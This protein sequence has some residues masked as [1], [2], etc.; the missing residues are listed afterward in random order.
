MKRRPKRAEARLLTLLD[1]GW[2]IIGTRGRHGFATAK[3]WSAKRRVLLRIEQ[4]DLHVIRSAVNAG[5]C[6]R[7]YVSGQVRVHL[8]RERRS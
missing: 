7:Q 4:V 8:N 1:K 6:W 5:R 2:E 3:Q